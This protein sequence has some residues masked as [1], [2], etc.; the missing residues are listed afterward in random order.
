MYSFKKC[1]LSGFLREIK[2]ISVEYAQF[3]MPKIYLKNKHKYN[4]SDKNAKQNS[5][6]SRK[7]L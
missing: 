4:I 1:I 3:F 5:L 7:I 6:M 2:Y